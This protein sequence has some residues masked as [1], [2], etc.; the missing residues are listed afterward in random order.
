[1]LP[2]ASSLDGVFHS[3][4]SFYDADTHNFSPYSIA[5]RA[6]EEAGRIMKARKSRTSPSRTSPSRTS[7]SRTSPSRTSPS[8]SPKKRTK[9]LLDGKSRRTRE[10][11][12]EEEFHVWGLR[13]SP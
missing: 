1:M 8:R 7:P 6:Y 5:E 11:E 3:D 10:R 13:H 4:E 2:L 9:R 12:D